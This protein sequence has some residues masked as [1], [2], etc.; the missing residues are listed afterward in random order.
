[1]LQKRVIPCLLIKNGGLVKTTK[2]KKPSYVGD[3]INT[4]KIFNEKEVDELIILDIEASKQG[5]GPDFNLVA[6]IASECFI[7]LCYGGGITNLEEAKKLFSI[8]VEK[9]CIQSSVLKDFTLL[10]QI[11]NQF[12][13]Q[14]V[15]VSIDI[16]NNWFN[17]KSLYS[18]K[19]NRYLRKS[20]QAFIQEA[21]KSGAGEI[22]VNFVDK[23]GM[24]KGQDLEFI[25][26]A[27]NISSVPV[28]Y[29]GGIGSLDDI[30]SSI[31][32]GADAVGAGS[33]FVYHGPHKAVLITYPEYEVIRSILKE[34]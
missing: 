15:V 4:I 24:R 13:S 34:K 33:F 22:V 16:K 11:S 28:I 6:E 9:I 18:S 10:S 5:N 23:D 29:I 30:K 19:N 14:S 8:G 20:W 17:K 25:K 1:M 27:G 12:G 7:P 31:D 3:P 26:E 2:F 21:I 32:S